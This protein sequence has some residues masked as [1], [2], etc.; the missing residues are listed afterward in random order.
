[1]KAQVS[2]AGVETDGFFV[3]V[4][5]M[6]R[7]YGIEKRMLHERP[8]HEAGPPVV[9][10][11]LRGSTVHNVFKKRSASLYVKKELTRVLIKLTKE[12]LAWPEDLTACV[13]MLSSRRFPKSIWEGEESGLVNKMVKELSEQIRSARSRDE[14]LQRALQY[15]CEDEKSKFWSVTNPLAA[16]LGVRSLQD[17]LRQAGLPPGLPVAERDSCFDVAFRLLR[18]EVALS[19]SQQR[20]WKFATGAY[21]PEIADAAAPG[22]KGPARWLAKYWNQAILEAAE[23]SCATNGWTSIL[24]E[25]GDQRITRTWKCMRSPGSN[26]RW[27]LRPRTRGS[28][29]NTYSS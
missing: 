14:V 24:P 29:K 9:G 3:T 13:A 23:L 12:S 20:V 18:G 17:E 16:R 28:E 5:H 11:L 27:K 7:L 2:N 6:M 26:C 22:L 1:M 4:G 25:L 8:A 10:Q 21:P 19:E 15:P